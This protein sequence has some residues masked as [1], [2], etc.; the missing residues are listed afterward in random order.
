MSK[1][2][3]V[4]PPVAHCQLAVARCPLPVARQ[5]G[6]T[7]VRPLATADAS[8]HITEDEWYRISTRDTI[9]DAPDR[10]RRSHGTLDLFEGDVFVSTGTT[11]RDIDIAVEEWG[12]EPPLRIDD[13]GGFAQVVEI[14]V[15]FEAAR[16]RVLE[17]N[18][19]PAL[20]VELQGG[21]GAYRL[22]L[23]SRYLDIRR[24]QHL[25]RLWPAPTAREWIYR[26]DDD[27]QPVERPD[28]T[29]TEIIDVT[30]T[31]DQAN[32]VRAE[33]Q[34]MA[35]M[36]VQSGDIDDIVEDCHQIRD[37]IDSHAVST[38]ELS[39]ALTARQWK[40]ALAVLEHHSELASE[41]AEADT[42]RRIRDVIV[43]QV[44]HLPPGRVYG[45]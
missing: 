40:V 10:T 9:P 13:S 4:S 3:L 2:R 38:G 43:S 33:V 39:V 11:A 31:A 21:T 24:Q 12:I 32:I 28:R 20:A 6:E 22:R 5:E 25:L 1:V 16:L 26:L 27:A 17:A 7:P 8:V 30:M 44:G 34:E 23:H 35:V 15:R 19:S 36:E 41:P 29:A 45:L 18:G 42:M 14:S 37:I